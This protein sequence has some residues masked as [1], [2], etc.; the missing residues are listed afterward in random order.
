MQVVNPSSATTIYSGISNAMVT[1]VRAE[2]LRNLW[3]GV[4]S[5]V[6]G[7]GAHAAR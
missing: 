3:R 4:S 6:L 7:A 1:I 5:V 2:G